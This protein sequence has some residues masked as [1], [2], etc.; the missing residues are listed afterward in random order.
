MCTGKKGGRKGSVFAGGGG[1]IVVPGR[2]WGLIFIPVR[3]GSF[4]TSFG[5]NASRFIGSI[6]SPPGDIPVLRDSPRWYSRSMVGS[7]FTSPRGEGMALM[8]KGAF[9][10]GSCENRRERRGRGDNPLMSEGLA[11]PLMGDSTF[12]SPRRDGY[13]VWFYAC[14]IIVLHWC[15]NSFKMALN[16]RHGGV[17][18]VLQCYA[19]EGYR[20]GSSLVSDA[21]RF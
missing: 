6:L 2:T 5:R 14:V 12:A 13:L 4:S 7:I 3:A 10:S 15:P 16:C 17:T 9:P 8:S 20:S 1:S 21:R 18:V 11:G 19:I